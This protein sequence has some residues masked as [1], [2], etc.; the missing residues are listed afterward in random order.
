MATNT[1]RF[2]KGKR[3]TQEFTLDDSLDQ[4]LPKTGT[5]SVIGNA[6]NSR[7]TSLFTGTN[8]SLALP[9]FQRLPGGLI[10]QW[11]T[12]TFPQN[13]AAGAVATANFTFPVSFQQSVFSMVMSDG[14]TGIQAVYSAGNTLSG[15]IAAVRNISNDV[16]NEPVG[17]YIAIGQ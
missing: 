9:G 15:G 11:G 4:V 10:L 5:G 12:V 7:V 8:Q 1:E 17:R 14:G 6:I 3:F 2:I 16:I 13:L